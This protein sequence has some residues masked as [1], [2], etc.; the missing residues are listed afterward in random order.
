MEIR[1][2]P[3]EKIRAYENNP[4]RIPEVAVKTLVNSIRE[5]GFK[6]PVVLD[7]NYV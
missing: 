5:F 7:E 6:V 2:I 3:L 1:N 4:R